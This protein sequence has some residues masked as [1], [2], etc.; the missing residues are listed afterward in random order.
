MFK[1]GI[2]ILNYNSHADTIDLTNSLLSFNIPTLKIVIVDNCS[3]L[4]G[5]DEVKAKFLILPNVHIIENK[6]NR[7][8][9][10]GNNIGIK[11]LSDSGVRYIVISNPDITINSPH[12]LDEM[13]Y[14]IKENKYPVIA[15]QVFNLKSQIIN[16]SN[17]KRPSRKE[18]DK[19]KLKHATVFKFLYYCVLSLTY[20]LSFNKWNRKMRKYQHDVDVKTTEVY[21]VHGSFFMIDV[22]FFISNNMFPVFDEN[23]FLFFEEYIIAEKVKTCSAKLLLI[24]YVNVIH[25][26]DTSQKKN[27]IDRIRYDILASK[28]LGYICKKYFNK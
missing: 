13:F 19:M 24:N 16:P 14:I 28:S 12:V 25:K 2:V 5:F 18:I 20:L 21:R 8:Y 23:V 10:Y 4:E 3:S 15:P 6:E 22:D 1:Y 27:V 26:E 17:R 7:G 11:Y 9:G